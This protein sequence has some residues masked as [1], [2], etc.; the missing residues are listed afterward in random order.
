MT[1]GGQSGAV[2]KGSIGHAQ[3]RR[4]AVHPLYEALLAAGNVLGQGHGGVVARHHRHR[5]EHIMDGHLLPFLQVDLRPAH[6]GRPGGNRDHILHLEAPVVDGLHHQQQ[7]HDLGNAGR[8]QLVVGILF[9]KHR[10][11]LLLHQDGGTGF[12]RRTAGNGGGG[13]DQHNGGHQGRGAFF[14]RDLPPCSSSME[15]DVKISLVLCGRT[16]AKISLCPC[17][18][19]AI[20]PHFCKHFQRSHLIYNLPID[21]FPGRW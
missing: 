15:E 10:A 9:V 14:H 2:N 19:L 20:Q 11:G 13:Q 5:L 4:A 17:G 1:G 16:P 12:H 8:L 3:L 7:G 6:G 18:V 21:F